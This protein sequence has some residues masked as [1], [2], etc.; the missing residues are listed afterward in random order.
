M[1]KYSFITVYSIIVLYI[2]ITEVILNLHF[3]L[4]T[5]IVSILSMFFVFKKTTPIKIYLLMIFPLLLW[6]I[7]NVSW[8]VNLSGL[9]GIIFAKLIQSIYFIILDKKA[10]I[11]I[12]LIRTLISI[13]F[14]IP[15]YMFSAAPGPQGTELVIYSCM[16]ASLI[17]IEV[18]LLFITKLKK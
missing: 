10:P 18:G 8:D 17:L 12:K 1:K 6:F 5:F 11:W 14:V 7:G 9:G 15:A 13:L 16:A 3:S 2:F 4:I